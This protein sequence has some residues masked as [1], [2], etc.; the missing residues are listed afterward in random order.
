LAE[1]SLPVCCPLRASVQ[2]RCGVIAAANPVGGRYDASKNLL[3]NV[4]LSDPI[5]Q[6]FDIICVLQDTV[7]PVADDRLATFVVDS[8]MRSKAVSSR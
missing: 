8:H 2:A 7:D 6:R 1:L 3:E 5:I 4:H